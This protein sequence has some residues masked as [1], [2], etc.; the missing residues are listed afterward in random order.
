MVNELL[1]TFEQALDV[2]PHLAFEI[3]YTRPTDWMVHIWDSTGV[4]I[5]N[6]Q[7]IICTQDTDKDKA[8]ADAVAQ[9]KERFGL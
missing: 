1:D 2:R 3:G 9:L 7:K 5:G 4:G 6:A 8:C